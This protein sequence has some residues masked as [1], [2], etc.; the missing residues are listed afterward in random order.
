MK[1]FLVLVAFLLLSACPR[2]KVPCQKPDEPKD[3]VTISEPEE[4][5]LES[6]TPPVIVEEKK[7]EA[8]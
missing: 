7:E 5:E 4:K 8:Q 3:S 1:F 6:V 2:D